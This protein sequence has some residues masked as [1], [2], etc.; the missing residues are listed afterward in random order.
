MFFQCRHTQ[1]DFPHSL[2]PYQGQPSRSKIILVLSSGQKRTSVDESWEARVCMTHVRSNENTSCTKRDD[3]ILPAK[4]PKSP[5][6]CQRNLNQLKV[7]KSWRSNV[8]CN[9]RPYLGGAL[10]WRVLIETSDV[11]D[12]MKSSVR[13][14]FFALSSEGLLFIRDGPLEKWW[15]AWGKFFMFAFFSRLSAVYVCFFFKYVFLHFK[16]VWCMYFFSNPFCLH[17][18]FFCFFPTLP[19]TFLM[20]HP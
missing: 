10:N 17:G 13:C 15:E 5:T 6:N 16:Q 14:C 18:F 20:V 12:W 11:F 8:S 19:I 3:W 9:S 7:D 2:S 4:R 1:A